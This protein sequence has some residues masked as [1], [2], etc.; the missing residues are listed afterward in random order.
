M[1]SSGAALE[2]TPQH[3]ALSG[4]F[5]GNPIVPAVLLLDEVLQRASADCRLSAGAQ[6]G[7]KI[8]H[9]KFYRPV[10]PGEPLSLQL[11]R[12]TDGSVRFRL[13]SAATLIAQGLLLPDSGLTAPP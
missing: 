12:P 4:H 10:R 5:P 6:P 11:E 9:A 7:W 2:V 8:G 3:P 1:K 13:T